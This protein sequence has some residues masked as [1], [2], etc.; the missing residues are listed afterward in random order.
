MKII[1]VFFKGFRNDLQE[2]MD[3]VDQD[4]LDELLASAGKSKDDEKP[5]KSQEV[6]TT[7]E[8]I[9]EMAK[10]M[11]RGDRDH[12]MTVIVHFIQVRRNKTNENSSF[13]FYFLVVFL[14]PNN[15]TYMFFICCMVVEVANLKKVKS[16]IRFYISVYEIKLIKR[17]Q[18]NL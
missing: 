3:Q 8:Q 7:Y 4:Y 6:D 9:Q 10:K 11:G 14:K 13:L 18:L 15:I 2:A 16:H 5:D 12:D 1:T 17:F